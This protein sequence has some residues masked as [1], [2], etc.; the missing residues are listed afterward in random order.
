MTWLLLTLALAQAD[1]S[2][3]GEAGDEATVVSTSVD[4]GVDD[5]PLLRGGVG[6]SKPPFPIRF[7]GNLVLADEVYRAVLDVPKGALPEAETAQLVA[8]QLQR[9]LL[10][11]GYELA[12]V[13]VTL[14]D[15]GLTVRIDEG[16]LEKVVFRGRFTLPMLRF[17]IAVDLPKEVFNRPLLEREVAQRAKELGIEPPTWELIE[18][19]EIRHEGVQVQ[20]TPT[21]V[22][23]GRSLIRPQ[24]R[25]ELHFTFGEPAWST[26]LGVDLRTSWM[27]GLEVGLNYQSK[28]LAFEKDRWRVALMGG[29]GLRNDLP[30][31]NIYLFPSRLIADA[32]WYS[33][34]IDESGTSRAL[35]S[36]HTEGIAR[37]RRDFGLENYFAL[38]TELSVSLAVKPTPGVSLS[39]GAGMQYFLVGGLQAPLGAPTPTLP[40]FAFGAASANMDPTRLRNFVEARLDL[41]FFDGD[42]RYDRRHALFL[43]GRLSANVTRFDLPTFAEARL[44][45]QLVVPIGW[46]DVWIRARGTWMSGDVVFPFEEVLGEHLPAVFGDI[47]VQKAGGVRTE[48]RYSLARDIFKVGLFANAVAF[49]E[50]Q[51]DTGKTTPRFGAGVGPTAHLLVEGIFQLDL[52]L[53]FSVLSS[54][55]FSTGLLVWIN[56]VF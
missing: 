28:G 30:Q 23:A 21:L 20:E 46:H 12:T 35:L 9:F 22:I 43:E 8:D 25:F 32:I 50:E 2:D 48:F 13:S 4:G 54:G 1:G 7:E 10:K 37:Q 15:G 38:R 42:S 40:P 24:Q 45:Y 6:L 5:G 29:L 11:S 47:W 16:R 27:D 3:A 26:G 51:R 56:K 53:N 14:E 19:E 17:K 31:N 36:L 18:T 44:G 39:G 33:P 55:R 49:G 41:V 34:A 52:F